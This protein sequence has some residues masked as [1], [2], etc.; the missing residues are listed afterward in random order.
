MK[1]K[2]VKQVS[3]GLGIEVIGLR[4]FAN[5][6]SIDKKI[7]TY[8][9]SILPRINME[10]LS[11]WRLQLHIS[12]LP[13][14]FISVYKKFLRYPSDREYVISIGIP[15]P[16]NTQAPYGMPTGEDGKISLFCRSASG[17][18]SHLLYPE[19]DQYDNLNQYILASAIKAIDL[20]FTKGFTCYGKKI[21]F[22]DL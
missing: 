16:D 7:A 1:D 11:G 2:K 18:H 22:Q 8:V 10:D 3:I 6:F 13:T 21:K 14:D 15:I 9:K 20:G 19:Y 5:V 17:K 12:Y 4:K